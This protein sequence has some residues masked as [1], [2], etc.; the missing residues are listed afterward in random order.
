MGFQL[1]FPQLVSLPDFFLSTVSSGKMKIFSITVLRHGQP[2]QIIPIDRIEGTLALVACSWNMFTDLRKCDDRKKRKNTWKTFRFTSYD[3]QTKKQIVSLQRSQNCSPFFPSNG[4]PVGL[5]CQLHY[6]GGGYVL[7]QDTLGESLQV[8]FIK[9]PYLRIGQQVFFSLNQSSGRSEAVDIQI[10]PV[11]AK[12]KSNCLDDTNLT[13]AKERWKNPSKV[14][15]SHSNSTIDMQHGALA[16]GLRVAS[17]KDIQPQS[18]PTTFDEMLDQ[19]VSV[20]SKKLQCTIGRFRNANLEERLAMIKGAEDLLH[21][22]LDQAVLD[23]DAICKVVRKCAGWLHVPISFEKRNMEIRANDQLTSCRV[24][25]QFRV[26]RLLISALSHLDLT[27]TTTYNAIEAALTFLAKMVL[28][29]QSH[30]FSSSRDGNAVTQW[31]ELKALVFQLQ[32]TEMKQET[33]QYVKVTMTGQKR[34]LG[35]DRASASEGIYHPNARVRSLTSVFTLEKHIQ[36]PSQSGTTFGYDFWLLLSIK[37]EK[38]RLYN[39]VSDS[40]M[41]PK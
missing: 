22:L 10:I 18:I 34:M 40:S 3:V 17:S 32:E 29:H 30:R 21:H 31:K 13:D 15:S 41:C 7:Y 12:T 6:Q 39:I 33:K 23:G 19:D 26:R 27:D 11:D 4:M 38:I 5:V 20:Q 16:V 14:G 24:E 37:Y 28:Q 25:L 36:L 1:P 8:P 2:I 35:P 9:A